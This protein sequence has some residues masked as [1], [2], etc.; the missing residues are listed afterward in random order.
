[1]AKAAGPRLV[2]LDSAPVAEDMLQIQYRGAELKL[3]ASV[4]MEAVLQF[5][6]THPSRGGTGG[7]AFIEPIL[8]FQSTHPSRGGTE[9]VVRPRLL[10]TISI[11]P[12][13]A[14]WD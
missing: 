8:K 5:H 6:S 13:L 11:H 2:Q 3:P 7:Y 4:D 12:P 14:G 1:M 10:I 9:T